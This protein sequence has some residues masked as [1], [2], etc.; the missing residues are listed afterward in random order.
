MQLGGHGVRLVCA[1]AAV[2]E[3]T[4]S[5]VG[6]AS[7]LNVVEKIIVKENIKDTYPA[8]PTA[9]QVSITATIKPM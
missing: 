5:P 3:V 9:V 6:Y 7:N 4:G 8:V 2:E 1:A